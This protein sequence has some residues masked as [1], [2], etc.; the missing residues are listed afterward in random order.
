MLGDPHTGPGRHQRARGGDVERAAGVAA[1][2]AGVDETGLV[3]VDLRGE[4]PHHRRGGRDLFHR[5]ALYPQAYQEAADLR[6]RALAGH[7]VL[8]DIGHLRTVEVPP[9]DDGANRRLDVHRVL[10][11]P[12]RCRAGTRAADYV[13][14]RGGVP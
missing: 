3:D 8:H 1:G 10:S 6:G 14:D 7:D 12:V 13:I 5:F 11:S 2:T 9:R 4:A